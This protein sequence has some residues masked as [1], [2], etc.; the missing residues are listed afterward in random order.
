MKNDIESVINL[1]YIENPGTIR[2]SKHIARDYL[3]SKKHNYSYNNTFEHL[4]IEGLLDCDELF[5]EVIYESLSYEMDTSFEDKDLVKYLLSFLSKSDK[6]LY[7][8]YILKNMTHKELSERFGKE[9]ST[10]SKRLK[11]IQKCL[12]WYYSQILH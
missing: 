6:K 4:S 10:I 3:R 1:Y 8:M 11:E 12:N 7:T 9:R 2:S 5:D